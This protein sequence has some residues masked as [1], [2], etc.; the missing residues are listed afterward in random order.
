MFFIKESYNRPKLSGLGAPLFFI[1]CFCNKMISQHRTVQQSPNFTDWRVVSL[2]KNS[3]LKQW[4]FVCK[5][6]VTNN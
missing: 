3:Y 6:N 4:Y 1:N 2:Q 5:M